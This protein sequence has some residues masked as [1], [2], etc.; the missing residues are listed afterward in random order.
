MKIF[1][2]VINKVYGTKGEAFMKIFYVNTFV[3]YESLAVNIFMSFNIFMSYHIIYSYP[4]LYLC[5]YVI[6]FRPYN[7]FAFIFL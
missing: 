2:E 3:F 4:H 1:G 7:I 6:M 5:S